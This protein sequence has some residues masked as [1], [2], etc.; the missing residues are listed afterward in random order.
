M[1]ALRVLCAVCAVGRKSSHSHASPKS[2]AGC[3]VGGLKLLNL[4][5]GRRCP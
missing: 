3:I 2:A 4:Q 5:E 1:R